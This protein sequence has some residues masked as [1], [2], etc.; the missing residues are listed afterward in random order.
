VPNLHG[1]IDL[2]PGRKTGIVI[3][4]DREGEFGA[5]CAE[6]CGLQHAHMRMRIVAEPMGRFRD[7][8]DH[9]RQ[10]AAPPADP[11]ARRGREVFLSGPC[12]TCHAVKG[13]SASATTGPDLTHVASRKS[14][15][16]DSVPN[17]RG[18]LAGWILDAQSIKPGAHMPSMAMPAE[19]VHALI[20][21]L[22][23]LR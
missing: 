2:I 6:F 4:A 11:L 20:A 9:Q 3:Q 7:W 1:K 10:N 17:T 21:Y 8:L 18:H 15:A 16:A 14:L 5:Q 22:E 19:D 13:T 12:V 23:T